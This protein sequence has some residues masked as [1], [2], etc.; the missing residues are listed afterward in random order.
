MPP[1]RCQD[2]IQKFWKE[3]GESSQFGYFD[4]P[5]TF[6]QFRVTWGVRNWWYLLYP[7]WWL[8]YHHSLTCDLNLNRRKAKNGRYRRVDHFESVA[9][10]S[11]YATMS[12]VLGTTSTN[13]R[14]RGSR[15]SYAICGLAP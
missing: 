2:C 14:V 11:L 7:P 10:S 13:R 6:L 8:E 12:Y 15:W 9:D 4:E 3:A 5:L 1:E